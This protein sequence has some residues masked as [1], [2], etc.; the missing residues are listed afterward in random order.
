MKLEPDPQK[1]EFYRKQLES[2]RP[3]EKKSTANP[4]RIETRLTNKNK[5]KNNADLT[6]PTVGFG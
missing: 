3:V 1:S 5:N 4:I 2:N 6:R